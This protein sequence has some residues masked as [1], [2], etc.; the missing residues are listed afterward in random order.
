MRG[1]GALLKSVSLFLSSGRRASRS[2]AP[3]PPPP[4]PP[5]KQQSPSKRASAAHAPAPAPAANKK[6]GD[7]KSPAQQAILNNTK[8]S[9]KIIDSLKKQTHFSRQE[10]E[11]LSKV[12]KKLVESHSLNGP[13][14]A[15]PAVHISSIQAN[16]VKGEGLDRMVFRELLHNTF[17]VVTEEVL[18]DRIFCAFDRCNVGLIRLE[19]WVCGL[20]GFL[21]GSH[22]ERTAFA[23][24][25]YDLNSDGFISREEMFHLL[26]NSL[27]KSPQDEDPD[28]GVRDLVELALRKM[29]YDRDGKISFQDFKNS[30]TDEP[31]LLE[32]FGQCLPADTACQTFLSTLQC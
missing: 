1:G 28:E 24:F 18:M 19:E 30:V 17:D 10:I 4:S 5:R 32:A 26:R 9:A 25:V 15:T 27:V 8:S 23:F 13:V 7:E 3:Q 6:M 16:I 12:Y 22:E 20:S 31:L 29:D 14:P 11:A 21:R 2:A